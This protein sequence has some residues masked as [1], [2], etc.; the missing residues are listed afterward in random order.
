MFTEKDIPEILDFLSKNHYIV[1]KFPDSKPYKIE[2]YVRFPWQEYQ[3]VNTLHNMTLNEVVDIYKNVKGCHTRII[4][5]QD[6]FPATATVYLNEQ[7]EVVY[8]Q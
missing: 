7:G 1:E 2:V 3:F 6:N 8:K 5:Y 4:C